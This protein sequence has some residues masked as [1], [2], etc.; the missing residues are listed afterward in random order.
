M[1]LCGVPRGLHNLCRVPRGRVP[2]LHTRLWNAASARVATAGTSAMSAPAPTTLTNPMHTQPVGARR[3]PSCTSRA[4][5]SGGRCARRHSSARGK[6][7]YRGVPSVSGTAP[8]AAAAAA[9]VP[10]AGAAAF[11]DPM[12]MSIDTTVASADALAAAMSALTSAWLLGSR[13][14]LVVRDKAAGVGGRGAE[15]L[16]VGGTCK[17]S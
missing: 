7:T 16:P 14:L 12:A 2:H 9:A 6:A 3:L 15:G 4:V 11:M 10:F 8:A 17:R 5:R 13:L 1:G